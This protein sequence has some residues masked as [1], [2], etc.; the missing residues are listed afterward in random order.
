MMHRTNTQV[1][2][3]Q[4]EKTMLLFKQTAHLRALQSLLKTE[5]EVAPDSKKNPPL[6]EYKT[7]VA[8][9]P[10]ISCAPEM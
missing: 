2:K 5:E 9:S 6:K 10:L 3:W 8:S 4:P 7:L 1:K